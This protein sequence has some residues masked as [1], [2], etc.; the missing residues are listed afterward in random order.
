MLLRQQDGVFT[1]HTM[2]YNRDFDFYT[3]APISVNSAVV[4]ATTIRGY[5]KI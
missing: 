2:I 5:T 4:V 1:Y 3:I